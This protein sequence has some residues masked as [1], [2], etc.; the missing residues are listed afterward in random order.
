MR[1]K[2]V[3]QDSDPN[4]Q[5]DMIYG[6][7]KIDRMSLQHCSPKDLQ[8]DLSKD[9]LGE[10]RITLSTSHAGRRSNPGG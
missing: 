5:L 2:K 8:P 4:H 7:L 9:A 10:L 3:S 1:A 6:M